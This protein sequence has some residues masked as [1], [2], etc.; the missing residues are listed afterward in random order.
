MTYEPKIGH[1]SINS[2]LLSLGLGSAAILAAGPLEASATSITGPET[3]ALRVEFAALS[4]PRGI[5]ARVHF[6]RLYSPATKTV[7]TYAPPAESR[8][9]SE[10]RD[11]ALPTALPG[12]AEGPFG[13]QGGRIGPQQ[14]AVQA[15]AP[16]AAKL[17]VVDGDLLHGS[18]EDASIVSHAHGPARGHS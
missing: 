8:R 10:K 1:F 3:E 6:P 7:E 15:L 12:N 13:F 5:S 11:S 18:I 17:R 9:V 4:F 2:H 16:G 14:N